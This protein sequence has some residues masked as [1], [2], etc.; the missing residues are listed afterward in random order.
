MAVSQTN[1][2]TLSG[3]PVVDARKY[4][5][6][7]NGASDD[8]AALAAGAT[9][10]AG[11]TLELPPGTYRVSSNLT[12]G[13]TVG[14]RFV[15]GAMLSIDSG[16]TVTI[17][18]PVEAGRWQIFSG[19]GTVSFGQGKVERF[20]PHWWGVAGTGSVDDTAEWQKCADE[21]PSG[22]KI[23]MG[24][25]QFVTSATITF[26]C[27]TRRL[28]SLVGDAPET[29]QFTLA[30][31][32]GS[33]V[34]LFKVVAGV[35]TVY[36]VEWSNFKAFC[37]SNAGRHVLHLDAT[38]T[39][40]TVTRFTLN[41]V[42]LG[43]AG[44]GNA[45]VESTAAGPGRG[46]CIVNTDGLTNA[47]EDGVFGIA[48]VRSNVV[49]GATVIGAGD[50]VRF[51][52]SLIDGRN[53][54]FIDGVQG[55]V[56]CIFD[57]TPIRTV[58][59]LKIRNG[60]NITFTGNGTVELPEGGAGTDGAVIS[61]VG[62]LD[63]V[64]PT[65]RGTK[66]IGATVQ[67]NGLCDYAIRVE[68]ADRTVIQDCELHIG[69]VGH[70]ELASTADRT[71]IRPNSYFSSGNLVAPTITNDGTRTRGI[72][73]TP[74]FVNSWANLGGG[75]DTA[76]FCHVSG[77]SPPRVRLRGH[78]TG[79]LVSTTVFTLPVGFRPPANVTAI[80]PSSGGTLSVMLIDSAGAVSF[81]ALGGA[82]VGLHNVEFAAAEP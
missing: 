71:E 42:V 14:L 60:R 45:A 34:D 40:A 4:G 35:G 3:H 31:G 80:V 57:N 16:V 15:C 51:H 9:A 37:Q 25:G 62:R 50:N 77:S 70:I 27:T 59:G 72:W 44:T 1:Y 82:S 63:G 58:G 61:I 22:A 81:T 11:R 52:Q 39:G 28:P 18:G 66:I 64:L 74:T 78:V 49:D 32:A 56:G 53:N 47:N 13:A 54:V 21:V 7:G 20:Y 55:T 36:D 68:Q 65:A 24:R 41:Q 29:T 8:R 23:D 30:A 17:N 33:T 38:A 73:I 10:A 43:P 19:S 26:D 48:L 6:S 5:A 67:P 2:L 69:D 46:L 12:I 75:F 79:G 76:H